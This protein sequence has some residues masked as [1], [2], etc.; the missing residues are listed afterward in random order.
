MEQTA[1]TLGTH[2]RFRLFV[3]AGEA[4]GPGHACMEPRLP[5]ATSPPAFA[6]CGTI[7]AF[8]IATGHKVGCGGLAAGRKME[9]LGAFP[10]RTVL[11]YLN[12]NQCCNSVHECGLPVSLAKCRLGMA[13]SGGASEIFAGESVAGMAWTRVRKEPFVYRISDAVR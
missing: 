2:L 6:D 1:S 7:D 11:E 13:F 10:A 9:G 5:S 8:G 3:G 4:S 12:L